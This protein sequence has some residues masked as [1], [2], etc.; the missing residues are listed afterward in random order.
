[1][2]V[3]ARGQPRTANKEDTNGFRTKSPYNLGEIK[4]TFASVRLIFG[5]KLCKFERDETA[6][7]FWFQV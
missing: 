4:P 5:E 3:R 2:S 6:S 7:R 1:M